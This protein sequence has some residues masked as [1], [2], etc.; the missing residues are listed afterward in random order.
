VLLQP[1]TSL[2]LDLDGVCLRRRRAGMFDGFELATGCLDFLEWATARFRCRWLST[3]CRSGW[4]DGARRAF[5]LAGAPLD[6][7]RWAVL[8]LI[9]PAPWSIN[10]TDA[11]DPALDFWWI[12]D[13]P[14]ERDRG[15]LRSHNREDRLIE[16]SSD[17]D[18]DALMIARKR[19][20][21][22]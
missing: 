8:D 7:P 15:W 14:A 22:R 11:I 2:F 3:R 4:A 18:P 13:D 16:I 9:E 6:E 17:R 21:G 20:P 12:D 10:K 19:L 1:N 5:R